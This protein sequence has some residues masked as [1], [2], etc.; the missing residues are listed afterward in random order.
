MLCVCVE[1]PAGG[2]TESMPLRKG[3]AAGEF[4]ALN[5]LRMIA[6]IHI[7][8]THFSSDIRDFRETGSSWL[9]YF[10]CL[11]GVGAATS[12]IAAGKAVGKAFGDCG[13]SA[14][15]SSPCTPPT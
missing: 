6:A 13:P 2:A 4:H 14:V 5:S 10:F 8:F 3:S 12:R 15:A 11:S 1:Q 7:I 9:S